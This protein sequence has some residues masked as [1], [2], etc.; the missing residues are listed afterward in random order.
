MKKYTTSPSSDALLLY[1][2]GV[3]SNSFSCVTRFCFMIIILCFIWNSISLNAPESLH[4]SLFSWYPWYSSCLLSRPLSLSVCWRL[5]MHSLST[6]SEEPSPF[7]FD[8]HPP[9]PAA[10]SQAQATL[11]PGKSVSLTLFLPSW[12][13]RGFVHQ[14]GREKV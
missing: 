12:C 2:R 8:Q 10:I 11:F 14:G 6:C 4:L 7:E 13:F 5:L 3:S 9:P 1:L